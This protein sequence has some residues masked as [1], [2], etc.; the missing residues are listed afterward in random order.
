MVASGQPSADDERIA[1]PR[2]NEPIWQPD[3][4]VLGELEARCGL[5][6]ASSTAP[7]RRSA[8][9]SPGPWSARDRAANEWMRSMGVGRA[10]QRLAE[11]RC[12]PTRRPTTSSASLCLGGREG[13]LAAGRVVVA[14]GTAAR[15]QLAR[16][17]CA[18][19]ACF[20]LLGS[21]LGLLER[22]LRRRQRRRRALMPCSVGTTSSGTETISYSSFGC[23]PARRASARTACRS[24]CR[25]R[26][27]PGRSRRPGLRAGPVGRV[28]VGHR[29]LAHDLQEVVWVSRGPPLARA[30]RMVPFSRTKVCSLDVESETVAQTLKPLALRLRRSAPASRS[31]TPPARGRAAASRARASCAEG[32]VDRLLGLDGRGTRCYGAARGPPRSNDGAGQS[33]QLDANHGEARS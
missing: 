13:A 23:R 7:C 12:F 1:Q 5:R 31:I 20:S 28:G 30:A 9:A 18:A 2:R 11:P 29:A 8:V 21:S 3:V 22:L 32:V 10:A 4:V 16:V 33:G 25:D 27:W 19:R 15:R 14:V 24:R 26:R 17:N 6:G